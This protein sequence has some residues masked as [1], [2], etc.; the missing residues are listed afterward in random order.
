VTETG[1]RTASSLVFVSKAALRGGLRNKLGVEKQ[2]V[3]VDTVRSPIGGRGRGLPRD[4][5]RW[6]GRTVLLSVSCARG[7]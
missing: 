2:F 5:S 4:R 6:R 3:A 7:S 1:S